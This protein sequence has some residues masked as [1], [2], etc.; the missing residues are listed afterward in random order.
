MGK[1]AILADSRGLSD[2]LVGERSPLLPDCE[3]IQPAKMVNVILRFA[4][5]YRVCRNILE[6][7]LATEY[8]TGLFI[9]TLHQKAACRGAMTCIH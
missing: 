3:A 7:N 2:P 6:A 8:R 9:G 4:Q 5:F 1:D